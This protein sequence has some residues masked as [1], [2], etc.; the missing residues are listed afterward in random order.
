MSDFTISFDPYYGDCY[1]FGPTEERI[2]TQEEIS[3]KNNKGQTIAIQE[4]LIPS[5]NLEDFQLLLRRLN[6]YIDQGVDE[7]VKDNEGHDLGWYVWKNY[8]EVKAKALGI[9][10]EG[11]TLVCNGYPI[12]NSFMYASDK[13][14]K[15]ELNM[16]LLSDYHEHRRA[17]EGGKK[18]FEANIYAERIFVWYDQGADP[19]KALEDITNPYEN[20]TPL[21]QRILKA[22]KVKKIA[23]QPTLNAEKEKKQNLK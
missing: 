18:S 13:V 14:K 11:I 2:L 15:N 5:K 1:D 7:N 16:R 22:M 19:N 6:S 8:K 3:S 20:T 17:I 9:S 12:E 10:D 23:E 21:M 4:A